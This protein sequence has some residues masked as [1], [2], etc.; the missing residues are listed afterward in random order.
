MG[1]AI[2]A[3]SIS[4]T[5]ALVLDLTYNAENKPVQI[6]ATQILYD[7]D[8]GR[9]RKTGPYGTT[10]YIGQHY[11]IGPDT[12]PTKYLFAAM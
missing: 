12:G 8:G 5:T 2:K 4:H 6:G 1:L 7:A 10:F 3:E 9:A 11:E